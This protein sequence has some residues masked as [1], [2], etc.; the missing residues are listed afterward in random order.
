MISD[1][2]RGRGKRTL[3][4]SLLASFEAV[5]PLPWIDSETE[6]TVSGREVSEAGRARASG[7][8]PAHESATGTRR[9]AAHLMVC[10]VTSESARSERVCGVSTRRSETSERTDERRCEVR[11]GEEEERG[12]MSR[13]PGRRDGA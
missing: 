7:R 6:L 1:G 2:E 8:T 10:M 4:T 3:A 9:R 5:A 13:V 12:A 11:M